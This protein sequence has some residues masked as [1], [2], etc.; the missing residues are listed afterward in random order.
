[1]DLLAWLVDRAV[2]YA[3][4]HPPS[5]PEGLERERVGRLSSEISLAAKRHAASAIDDETAERLLRGEVSDRGEPARAAIKDF[6]DPRDN[7]LYDR[8]YR[9]LTA[10]VDGGAVR[11]IDTTV[12]DLFLTEERLG[13]LSLEDA[14]AELALTEPR[15]LAVEREMSKR[16][17]QFATNPSPKETIQVVLTQ[18]ERLV[19][20]GAR[21]QGWLLRSDLVQAIVLR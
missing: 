11:P 3:D 4:A 10:A 16:R 13:R 17:P 19:G 7:F 9:L 1:M 6:G 21:G 20:F 2:D 12:R 18:I 5:S 8:A 15:L 14:F